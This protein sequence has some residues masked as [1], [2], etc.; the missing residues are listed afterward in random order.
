MH[1]R[2]YGGIQLVRI[3]TYGVDYTVATAQSN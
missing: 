3:H 2:G 1:Q